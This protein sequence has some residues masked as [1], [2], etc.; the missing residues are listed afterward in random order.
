MIA[1]IFVG[2]SH[3]ASH[4]ASPSHAAAAVGATKFAGGP[5]TPLKQNEANQLPILEDWQLPPRFQRRP[6]DEE[7]IA[8]INVCQYLKY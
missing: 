6:L 3:S 2:T 5:S 1:F 7:E 4:G 8:C